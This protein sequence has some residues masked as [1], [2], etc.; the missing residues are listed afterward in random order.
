MRAHTDTG[1]S[2][3][4][5]AV[6]AKNHVLPALVLVAAVMCAL[7][8][9]YRGALASMVRLW[10][11]GPMYS[12]GFTVPLVSAYLLWSRR[13]ALRALTPRPSWALGGAVLLAGVLMT[14]AGRLGGIQVLEQV[15][16]LVSLTAAVLILFGVAYLRVAWASLAYLLLMVPLWDGFTEGL[17]EPFQQR[18][19]AIGVWLLHADWHSGFPRGDLHHAPEAPDRGRAGLQRSELPR[20]GGRARASARLRLPSRQLATPRPAPRRGSCCRAVQRPA[21]GPH[22]HACVLRGGLAAP[23]PVPRVARPVRGRRRLRCALCR[24]ACPCSEK[25]PRAGGPR[26]RD[27]SRR[28][29][30]CAWR[31]FRANPR[32]SGADSRLLAYGLERARAAVATGAARWRVGG[33]AGAA[34]RVDRGSAVAHPPRDGAGRVARRRRGDRTALSARRRRRR[35]SVSGLFRVA[36]TEPGARDLPKRR[37]AQ[38]RGADAGQE[39]LAVAHSTP[40]ISLPTGRASRGCSG[41][42]S[43]RSRKPAAMS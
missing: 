10:N 8:F 20:G 41:T 15:A 28:S 23:R 18:S 13:S 26:A 29:H 1:A 33:V 9:A 39:R 24:P 14:V 16:F 43:T 40:T 37:G 3:G 35:R 17:H 6:M 36:G 32:V 31:P 34:W 30:S 19:A 12:Y 25:R 38:P 42:P 11:N 21:R 7:L 5:S 27:Y 2:V 4:G 22:L